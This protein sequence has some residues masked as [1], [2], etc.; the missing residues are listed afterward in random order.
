MA[1]AMMPL[2][3]SAEPDADD[4]GKLSHAEVQY[5]MAKKGGDRCSSCRHYNGPNDCEIVQPP[6]YPAGWCN[7]FEPQGAGLDSAAKAANPAV[8]VLP[9]GGPAAGAP[10][11]LPNE[12]PS[13]PSAPGDVMAHGRAIA[14]A[15]ALHAVGHISQAERDKHI[16]KSRAVIGQAKPARKPFGSFVP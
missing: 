8:P 16:G 13:P 4:A 12:A 1:M 7:K 15:K 9:Q 11:S 10:A 2:G 5:G 6:I 14:G 3:M